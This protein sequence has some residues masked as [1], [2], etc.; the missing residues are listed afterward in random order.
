MSGTDVFRFL[1]VER[2]IAD[3]RDW[4][5]ADWPKLWLYNAHY[6]DDLAADGAAAR[7]A[8]HRTL[9]TRWIAENPPGVGNGWEPYPTSL[10]I[11]NWIKWALAGNALEGG[12]LHSLGVQARWLRG[13]LEHHLLG[14]HLWANAKALAFAGVF[15]AGDEAARWRGEGLELLRRELAEQVL[16]DGGHFERSPMYHAIVLEDVLDLLQ[17]AQRFPGAIDAADAAAWRDA[18]R[19]ML[20]WLR[21]MTHPDGE[22]ALFNDAAFGIAPNLAALVVYARELGVAVD[23]RPLDVVTTL[24]DSGYV[25][26]EAGPAVLIADVGPIGPDYLPGHAHADTLSFELSLHGQRLLVNGGTSTYEPGAERQRQRGTAAHNAVQVDGADSSEVWAAFRVAQRARPFGLAID[27]T[28][29]GVRL[30]C[31]HD[32]YRRLPGRVIHRRAWQLDRQSL[33]VTDTLEGEFGEA[34]ARFYLS[35]RVER[36]AD[37]MLRLADGQCARWKISGGAAQTVAS[38]WHPRF[39]NCMDN[40]CLA[41]RFAGRELTTRFDWA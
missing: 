31:A 15:F 24:P 5:R 39:G 21:A 23:E 7:A 41:I 26:L 20:H 30:E 37:G 29:D 25:R 8:W 19:R 10:R 28:A 40:C 12:L 16:P 11:V 3:A 22:I 1:N 33:T 34:I 2:R 32:G 35:P 36:T 9:L 14:N 18:A 6:F 13:R 27:R 38:V 4:N 17:L